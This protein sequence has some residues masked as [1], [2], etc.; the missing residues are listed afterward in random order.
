MSG[1]SGL[2]RAL[3]TSVALS[4][5]VVASMQA[6]RAAAQQTAA[7]ADTV[8]EV[9]VT[10]IRKSIEQSIALK[11]NS[12]SVV[13]AITAE[14]IGKLPDQNVAETMQRV[15]G[16][17]ITRNGGEGA[18]F[19][20]RGISQNRILINGTVLVG[21]G[22][23]GEPVL[24]DINP[25]I[26]GGLEVIKSPSAE[27]TEGAL[28]GTVNLLTKRPLD[29]ASTVIAGRAQGLYYD[30]AKK[31]GWRGSFLLSKKLLDNKLGV[32][33]SATH[34]DFT[35][36]T[37]MFSTDGWVQANPTGGALSI[38]TNNDG[39]LNAS[40]LRD[41]FRPNRVVTHKL[42]ADQKRTGYNAFV[43]YKPLPNLE[44]NVNANYTDSAKYE[45]SQRLQAVLSNVVSGVT[46]DSEKTVTRGTYGAP[47]YRTAIYDES[48]DVTQKSIAGSAKWSPGNFIFEGT[49]SHT[50]GKQDFL[51]ATPILTPK[52]GLTTSVLAD[53]STSADLPT[54]LPTANYD[55]LN[56][57][58]WRLLSWFDQIDHSSNSNDEFKFDA[59]W[60]L[61]LP[62]IK[63]VKAG[64]R[65][66]DTQLYVYRDFLNPAPATLIA[67]KPTI[68]RN[69]DGAIGAEEITGLT[70]GGLPTN[71]FMKGRSGIYPRNWLGGE[72]DVAAIRAGFGLPAQT[73]RQDN[74]VKDA[75]QKT[76]AEYVQANL[77]GMLGDLNVR[78]NV[79][80]RNIHTE[81]TV[82]GFLVAGTVVTPVSKTATFDDIL[83][84]MNLSV[85]PVEDVIVRVAAAKVLT[86]P[87]L[88]L[89]APGTTLNVVSFTG[90]TGNPDLNPYKAT[91]YD[92]SVE[93][94]FA[95]L[96]LVSAAVFYKN[97]SSFTVN[98]TTSEFLQNGFN[99]GNYLITRPTNGKNGTIRGFELAY[100]QVFD[101]LPGML[102]GVGVAA[103]F[104]YTDSKTPLINSLTGARDPLPGLSKVSYNLSTFYENDRGN[105][106]LTYNWRDKSLD[107]SQG[108]ALGGNLYLASYGQLDAT[109][110]YNIS[111]NIKFNVEV[112]N[113]LKDPIVYYSGVSTRVKQYEVNDR[114]IYV[115][116]SASF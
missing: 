16:V 110:Q 10:G 11:K 99:T 52:A 81:R 55:P 83:P 92:A 65:Y 98:T 68:D 116:V 104:T 78:G 101:N 45:K 1:N 34:Y 50:E 69:G 93:W 26:L 48:I 36:E 49:A 43:Q 22:L 70:F 39:A 51:I 15:T 47:T 29:L 95:P 63:N 13:D 19:T 90:S 85:S 67:G 20:I 23:D 76:T 41:V 106:R 72:L 17:Q 107:T 73:P 97:V 42:Y 114:R 82:S 58:N 33:F 66:E 40:D 87:A 7:P 25:E 4:V 30:Q 100:Q 31:A 59:T 115:G 108:I 79:G 102:K 5:L 86:R 56:F 37:Q 109:A 54:F 62:W 80:L 61:T 112:V 71:G 75:Q 103:N 3:Q 44:F 84:S 88:S 89:I 12:D 91:Q 28:G 105:A 14:D 94:Y 21:A 8:E 60:D 96:S 38:D 77:D 27:N 111:E 53:F 46:V 9:I 18:G 74:S 113:I 2:R 6:D 57:N 32:L 64:V 35:R 24:S